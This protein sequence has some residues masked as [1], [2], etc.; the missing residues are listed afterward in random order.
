M[1]FSGEWTQAII[2]ADTGFFMLK[3]K[4]LSGRKKAW[5]KLECILLSRR[6][7]SV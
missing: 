7:Q 4:E 5:R 6:R 3:R 1:S 2:H